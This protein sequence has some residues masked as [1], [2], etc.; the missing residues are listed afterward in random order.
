MTHRDADVCVV[1]GGYA[2]LT[3]ARQLR[4][5]GHEVVVLEARDRVGGRV[6]TQHFEDGTPADFG[7]TW[8][9]PGHDRMYALAREFGI[10][11][12]PTFVDGEN[13]ILK[14]GK[15]HRYEGLV[16]AVDPLAMASMFLAM[17]RLD[18][19]A[20]SVPPD[21]PWKARQARV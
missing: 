5:A 7:G 16:P 17:K 19:M 8:L 11:T 2:G 12:Y 3:A 15:A 9:G 13:V 4:D 10:K 21:A 1:G 18:R 20:R 14:D 6:W